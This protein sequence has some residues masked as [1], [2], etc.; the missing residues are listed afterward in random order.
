[1]E[2]AERVHVY[3]PRYGRYVGR[4]PLA[5]IFA[6]KTACPKSNADGFSLCFSSRS[7]GT[8]PLSP[9]SFLTTCSH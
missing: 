2:L 3:T 1:M 4:R 9:L 8:L 7:R 6:R 5:S